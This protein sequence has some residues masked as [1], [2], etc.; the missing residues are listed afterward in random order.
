MTAAMPC[1]D[2]AASLR[3]A[4]FPV[5]G[6]AGALDAFSS[7]DCAQTVDGHLAGQVSEELATKAYEEAALTSAAAVYQVAVDPG[8]RDAVGGGDA[9]LDRALSNLV[10]SG[11]DGPRNRAYRRDAELVAK[12]WQRYCAKTE[13]GGAR[14]VELLESPERVI[15]RSD[16][17]FAF[18]S[19]LL[20]ELAPAFDAAGR[21]TGVGVHLCAASLD[22]L[23]AGEYLAVLN[24]PTVTGASGGHTPRI[25]EGRVVTQRATWHTTIAESGLAEV[26][27]PK[28]RYLATRRWRAEL[29]L[30]EQVF[31][32]LSDATKPMYVDFTSPIFTAVLC[33]ALRACADHDV[34]VTITEV[35]PGPGDAW[36]ADAEGHRYLSELHIF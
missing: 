26:V 8:F 10:E 17:G 35:L 14:P 18:G 16:G 1:V 19:T 32:A 12:Y 6:P 31:V 5:N 22:E 23:N 2:Q 15:A 21:R 30:P 29:G 27:G 20:D 34:A 33:T 24:D 3:I 28:E 25:T 9:M 4:A 13:F 7:P 11:V 36:V